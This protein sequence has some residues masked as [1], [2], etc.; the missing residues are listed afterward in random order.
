[1]L[2]IMN[3]DGT[4]RFTMP[5]AI[6]TSGYQETSGGVDEHLRDEAPMMSGDDL[7]LHTA[8]S[9]PTILFTSLSYI[10]QANVID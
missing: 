5:S 8:L 2:D 10:P 7:K 4:S 6:T 1:M 3:K 9:P